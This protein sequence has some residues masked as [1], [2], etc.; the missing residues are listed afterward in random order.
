MSFCIMYVYNPRNIY[1]IHVV[2]KWHT[3]LSLLMSVV[4]DE[5]AKK[6]QQCTGCENFNRPYHLI[7]HLYIHIYTSIYPY[8]I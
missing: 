1:S 4:Y 8:S 2:L 5:F 6:Q 7:F 3:K